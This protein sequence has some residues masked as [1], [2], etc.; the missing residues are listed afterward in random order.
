M[1]D[2]DDER[3]IFL[4]Q[5]ISQREGFQPMHVGYVR[6]ERKQHTHRM[7]RFKIAHDLLFFEIR[8]HD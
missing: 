5:Q 6:N 3:L 7:N 8:T 1:R 2:N 4:R